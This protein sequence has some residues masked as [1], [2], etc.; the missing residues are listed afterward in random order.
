MSDTRDDDY[1]TLH[2]KY[3]LNP[4]LELCFWCGKETGS[5]AL[6]GN[7]YDGE[8]PMRMTLSYAP[9]GECQKSWEAGF[10]LLECSDTPNVDDQPPI[11][12]D[13]YP[14]GNYMVISIEAAIRLL[15]EEQAQ[16]KAAYVP[17]EQYRKLVECLPKKAE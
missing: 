14:T 9:C 11:K 13:V 8:A 17:L 12:P 3:G 6:L 5:I 4:T 10:V 7:K 1:I 16:V 15:G 2:P